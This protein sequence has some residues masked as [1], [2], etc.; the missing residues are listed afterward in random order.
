MMIALLH[1]RLLAIVTLEFF[2][3]LFFLFNRRDKSPLYHSGFVFLA[4]F[5]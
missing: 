5:D 3:F 2:F 1:V 4:L